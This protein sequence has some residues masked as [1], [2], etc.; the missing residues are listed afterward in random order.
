MKR[1]RPRLS[2][3]PAAQRERVAPHRARVR[4]RSRRSSSRSWP[5]HLGRRRPDVRGGRL[6]SPAHP[7]VSGRPAQAGQLARVGG[8]QARRDPHA[9]GATCGARERSRAILARSWARRK[10]EQRLPAHLGEAEMSRLLE[11]PDTL[12][13]ARPPRPRDP[14]A[15][16]CLGAAPQRACRPRPRGRQ[17]ERPGGARAG[18][19][20]QGADRAVQPA[21]RGGASRVD[22]GPGDVRCR[23]S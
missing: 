17:S 9:S 15:V 11:M 10:R 2:R 13:A 4:K 7:R 16:L 6:P 12:G 22:A 21:D 18:E 20:R 3:A 23:C 14:R 8:A 19:G 5:Q 1:A